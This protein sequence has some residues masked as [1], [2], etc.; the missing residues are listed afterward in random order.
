MRSKICDFTKKMPPMKKTGVSEVA[1][2]DKAGIRSVQGCIAIVKRKY[3]II[4][5]HHKLLLL[6]ICNNFVLC[7]QES[8]GWSARALPWLWALHGT[9]PS[10]WREE[11]WMAKQVSTQRWCQA[12]YT[13][14]YL[15]ICL[16]SSTILCIFIC[17]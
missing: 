10:S 8:V 1:T 7:L 2:R 11:R 13:M 12:A 16:R 17:T 14:P 5:Y 6:Y 4:C 15:C 9:A 3:I